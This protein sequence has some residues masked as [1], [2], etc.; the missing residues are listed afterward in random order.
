MAITYDE[1][2]A[3]TDEI[4]ARMAKR[5]AETPQE[6]RGGILEPLTYLG[7]PLLA[8]TSFLF[9]QSGLE[10]P[11]YAEWQP[12]RAKVQQEQKALLEKRG[13]EVAEIGRT[14]TYAEFENAYDKASELNEIFF[15][16]QR[17]FARQI[18]GK[19]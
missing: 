19:K 9:I 13:R 5:N 11:V 14:G 15:R 6:R 17:D 2:R 18:G 10:A 8:L 16:N 1:I 12:V 4:R 7:L 3:R